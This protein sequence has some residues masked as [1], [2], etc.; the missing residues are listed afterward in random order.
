M[1]VFDG[2]TN[3]RQSLCSANNREARFYPDNSD[4]TA[5]T[6]IASL[7]PLADVAQ[8]HPV[9]FDGNSKQS[10]LLYNNANKMN[11]FTH[12]IV[13]SIQVD[14]RWSYDDGSGDAGWI[15][16]ISLSLMFDCALHS[17]ILL[18][19]LMKP[20]ALLKQQYALS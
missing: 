4:G 8:I 1:A 9:S 17:A 16:K 3:Y 11:L 14:S 13:P 20:V 5:N 10:G 15:G 2:N 7:V 12:D 19:L 6:L 18:T